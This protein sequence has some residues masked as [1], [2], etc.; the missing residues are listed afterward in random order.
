MSRYYSG[1]VIGLAS[2]LVLSACSTNSDSGS[3]SPTTVS[4]DSAGEAEN[5]T[6]D[7]NPIPGNNDTSEQATET[8]APARLVLAVE[9]GQ[10]T[11]D[12]EPVGSGS[13]HP[14]L[15]WS[16]L[17]DASVYGVYL[18]TSSGEPYWFWRGPTNEVFVG[19]SIQLNDDALGVAAAPGMTWGVVAYDLNDNVIGV[20][21]LAAIGN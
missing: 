5:V 18:Y 2:L 12:L 6:G 15:S 14:L 11:I 21:E 3:V 7:D 1:L 20:S 13:L 4:A 17:T 16:E 19:G 8:T 9:S 10:A